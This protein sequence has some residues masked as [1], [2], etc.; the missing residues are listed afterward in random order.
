MTLRF[1]LLSAA[2]LALTACGGDA[3]DNQ[4]DETLAADDT[5]TAAPDPS[6]P[7]GFV[8]LA[9]SSNRFEIEAARLA[10]EQATRQEVK[11]FAAKMIEDHTAASEKLSAAVVAGGAPLAMPP[12]LLPQHQQLLDALR[13]AGDQFDQTYLQ[14][15]VT[16]HEQALTL[17][18]G[19]AE[20]GTVEPLKAFAAEAA[21]VVE[22]HLEQVRELAGL[23][24]E[25]A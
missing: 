17:L 7:Q 22:G 19:Q 8:D 23:A 1:A 2:A 21:P 14:Q 16:A 5:A 15:R 24:G 11:D 6:T 25:D 18:Q 4:T 13:N 3:V 10:Q 9:A 12:Q 20:R